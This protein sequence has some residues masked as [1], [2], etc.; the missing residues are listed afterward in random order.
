MRPYDEYI[1]SKSEPFKS[2]LLQLQIIIESTI[3]ELELK[4]KWKVPFYYYKGKPFC[5]LNVTNGYVDVGFWSGAYLDQYNA[6]L[7]SENRK[8][9]KSLRYFSIEEIDQEILISVLKALEKRG[10][11]GFSKK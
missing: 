3:S 7:I 5:Y 6:Y 2:I 10:T 9:M 1:L 8:V 4:Y 11:K